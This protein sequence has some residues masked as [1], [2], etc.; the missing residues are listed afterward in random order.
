MNLP[1]PLRA[2]LACAGLLVVQLMGCSGDDTAAPDERDAEA[3]PHNEDKRDK[4]KP[5]QPDAGESKDASTAQQQTEA[6][7]AKPSGASCDHEYESTFA[8]IQKV[9]LEG[10]KCTNDMCHGAAAMGDLDLRP[11][12]AYENLIER[13]SK[14][15]SQFRIMPG[16]PG[17]SFL[18]NK[19]RAATEPGSVKVEG[20]SMPVGEPAL[21]PEHLEVLRRWIEAGAPREGSVGDSVTGQSGSLAKLLDACLP[22][23]TPVAITPLSA[24]AKDE[25]VRLTMAPFKLPAAKEV[26]VCFAQHYDLSETVPAEYQDKEKGIFFVSSLRIRQDPQ[27]HHLLLQDPQL[28]P[29]LLDDKSFGSWACRGGDAEGKSC[30][31]RDANACGAGQCASE[32]QNKAA[33]VGFGPPDSAASRGGGRVAGAQTAQYYQPPRD[34]L[35][36][37]FPLRGIFYWN[38]HSFNLTTRDTTLHAW[39]NLYFAK[40]REKELQT[41]AITKNIS[42]AAGQKPFTV[43]KYCA[44]WVVPK[45]ALLYNMSSHTHK[46]GRNFSVDSHD[47]T[48]IYQS[49]IYTDPVEQVFDPPLRFDAESDAERTL[50][51]CAEFNNGLKKDGSPDL[52]LVTKLSTMPDRT[53]CK[54]VA[55]VAGKVGEPCGGTDDNAACDSSDGKGDGVC[56]ACEITAGQ[57][58]ENEMFVLSPS[59]VMP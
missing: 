8:A 38:S 57:T 20:S 52:D 43:E 9:I 27:S 15:S 32:V 23:S 40:N 11:D 28:S 44:D 50:K 2:R 5:E 13:K 55:C 49:V 21:S 37:T 34:G 29:E 14:L 36:T 4:K 56:D 1:R 6:Q 24:P 58:T 53:T 19:L 46:R 18:Y 39:I 45:N 33:C 42:I 35:Y 10:R 7:Q 51:Y 54:P 31:P 17:E 16:V 47:G 48:R 3:S 12:V 30:N 25:G 22:D 59:I 26:D 41:L